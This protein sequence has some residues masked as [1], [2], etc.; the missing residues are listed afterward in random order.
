MT[1]SLSVMFPCQREEK[2]NARLEEYDE[3]MTAHTV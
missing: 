3:I 2:I 1:H